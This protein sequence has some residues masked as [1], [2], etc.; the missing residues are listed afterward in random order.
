MPPTTD[1]IPVQNS[2]QAPGVGL[3]V[4]PT[5]RPGKPVRPARLFAGLVRRSVTTMQEVLR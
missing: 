2:G 1:P 5:T 4:S 3:D